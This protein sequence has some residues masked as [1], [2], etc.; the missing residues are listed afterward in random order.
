MIKN[1][2]T[3]FRKEVKT[4][5]IIDDDSINNILVK[6]ILKIL[7]PDSDVTSFTDPETGLKH[8]C[9]MQT[10]NFNGLVIFLDINMPVLSGWDV[11]DKL[12]ER[13]GS[14]LP[15]NS[16]LYITSSS[17]L[18]EDISKSKIYEMV[19]CYLS[20]PLKLDSL[21]KILEV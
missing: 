7:A 12:T 2:P 17:D 15:R 16:A 14:K 5:V 11:L 10:D 19:K 1:A 3:M 8:L 21:K 20:K 13:F 18:M 4:F 6:Y 9:D